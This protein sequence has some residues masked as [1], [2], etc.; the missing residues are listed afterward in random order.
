MIL[1]KKP[2]NLKEVIDNQKNMKHKLNEAKS[3]IEI[4]EIQE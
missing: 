4:L 1:S 2:K 3:E